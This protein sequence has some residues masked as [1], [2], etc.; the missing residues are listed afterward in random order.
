M[1]KAPPRRTI[2]AVDF[3]GDC[4][5]ESPLRNVQ[6]L[7]YGTLRAPAGS[8]GNEVSADE[9]TNFRAKKHRIEGKDQFSGDRIK[10]TPVSRDVVAIQTQT[11][12]EVHGTSGGRA[13]VPGT[14]LEDDEATLSARQVLS[15]TGT[16][17]EDE[18]SVNGQRARQYADLQPEI[19][20]QP[21][22]RRRLQPSS[23]KGPEQHSSH[24]NVPPSSPENH[25]HHQ[26]VQASLIDFQREP[27]QSE[28]ILG[29]VETATNPDPVSLTDDTAGQT[30]LASMNRGLHQPVKPSRGSGSRPGTNQ[31]KGASS[32]RGGDAV[33]ARM[34][35]TVIADAVQTR[36]APKRRERRR[37]REST[38]EGAETAQIESSAVKMVDLCRDVRTGKRSLI[39]K[40]L[41]VLDKKTKTLQRQ[42]RRAKKLIAEDKASDD[43]DN[44]EKSPEARGGECENEQR[45]DS[46]L[47]MER[48]G[49]FGTVNRAGMLQP[50]TRIVN[51]EIVLDESSL[52]IDRHANATANQVGQALDLIEESDLTRHIT[53]GSWL[54]RDKG[55]L[56]DAEHTEL[57]YEGLRMFGTDFGMIT[58]MFSDGRSRHAIKRKFCLEEKMYP[59]RME[60]TIRGE[61][62]PINIEEFSERTNTIY[63]DPQELE[64]D[65]AEDR[66]RLDEEQA[67]E[68]EA[69]EEARQKR[70]E[71]AAAESAAVEV[72]PSTVES[73]LRRRK[74]TPSDIKRAS[75][76]RKPPR[77]RNKQNSSGA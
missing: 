57:F 54:K 66:K 18:I 77:G 8:N 19:V 10:T 25:D 60:A 43:R 5:R 36:V 35:A 6:D 42:A 61:R 30:N 22:K 71:E 58:K 39:G 14:V 33:V 13:T 4:S 48:D 29:G 3:G 68:R 17:P 44:V 2:P 63:E 75:I 32:S 7:Q 50:A 47:E 20:E 69:L 9:A 76:A 73:G 49:A 45:P 23:E 27:H 12:G 59:S 51:G 16:A 26:S 74:R 52:R 46:G 24:A 28:E 62:V 56:W 41:R 34:A 37:Q 31:S 72:D 38:P 1:P 70:A 11:V 55:G 40:E 15:D 64:R 21:A 67:R 65:M 53:A